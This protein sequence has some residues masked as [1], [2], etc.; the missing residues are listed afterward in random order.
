MHILRPLWS[1]RLILGI[2][3][4]FSHMIKNTPEWKEWW[5]EKIVSNTGDL[6]FALVVLNQPLTGK[7]GDI[8]KLKW[9]QASYRVA[10]DG[11]ASCLLN[12]ANE[13]KLELVPDLI[14]GDFDSVTSEVLNIYEQ[15]GTKIIATPNQ[16]KTDFTKAL[17][18]MQQL[19]KENNLELDA[20]LTISRTSGRFDHVMGNL[21][22]L[23]LAEEM[24]PVSV[25]LISNNSLT[26]LLKKGKHKIKVHPSFC[27][28]CIGLIP[29]GA[30]CFQV[31]TTGLKWNL[32][33]GVLQF[34]TLVSTSNTFDDGADY[35]TIETD[36]NL[37]WTME[38]NQ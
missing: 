34:G 27:G 35:V 11:G 2:P 10:V 3:K 31:T 38:L 22:T 4:L 30:P 14:T 24:S 29:L 36:E 23:Y 15:K 26:W 8:V 28:K 37:I 21:N 33:H 32:D 17:E 6:K 13:H 12:L 7:T 5:P 16:D 18:E 19:L 9:Q 1:N 20:I 25:Y